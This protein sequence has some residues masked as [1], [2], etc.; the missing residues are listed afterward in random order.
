MPTLALD[1][2][3]DPPTDVSPMLNWNV[4]HDLEQ[5]YGDS[6]YLLDIAAFRRNYHD[7]LNAFLEF[8]PNSAIGYSYK[9]NYTPR[10]CQYVNRAGGYAEV[11][12]RMEYELA[13]RV[14]VPPARIIYNGPYKTRCDIEEALIQGTIVNLDSLHEVAHVEAI[15]RTWPNRQLIIGLRC[16]FDIGSNQPSRLG[17]DVKSP[18]FGEAF[19]RLSWLPNCI[20]G[21][22]HCHFSTNHRSIDS[23]ALRT[24]NLLELSAAYF[25]KVPPRFINIGGGFFSKMHPDLLDQFPTPVPTYQ[26]Y[27]RAIAPQVAEAFPTEPQ[28]E[29][30][31]EPG[32]AITADVLNFAAKI[33]DLKTVQS[34]TVALASGSIHNIKPT[35]HSKNMPLR[36]VR[37]KSE[38]HRRG[39]SSTLDIVGY[40][41]MEHDVLYTG[42][43]GEVAAGDYALFQNLGAY[44]IVMKPPFIRPCPPML[45]FDTDNGTFELIKRQ[46]E[47]DDV[48]ATFVF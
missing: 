39:R 47:P 29:L 2:P 11:V 17:I 26:D 14:G 18:D 44:T 13:L 32:S 31:L 9:T 3:V 25:S 12:S 6:F 4:L 33:I 40:T 24:Y 48:Y 20:I 46:E 41:C 36:L 8:Y 16:N 38:A 45:A 7:L 22:L 10:L 34:R 1:H 15:A 23:F 27:A 5:T 19:E 21:G 28:P 42:Y 43:E 30:I 37:A 35:L